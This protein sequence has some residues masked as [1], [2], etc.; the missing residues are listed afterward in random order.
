MSSTLARVQHILTRLLRLKVLLSTVLI[1][2]L[3]LVTYLSTPYDSSFRAFYRF[4]RNTLQGYLANRHSWISSA[5][6]HPVDIE[7]NVGVIIKTGYGTR[8]RVPKLLAAI[9]EEKFVTDTIVVQDYPVGLEAQYTWPNGDVVPTIDAIGWLIQNDLLKE[10][11]HSARLSK[12]S[13]VV[14]A[15]QAQDWAH[16]EELSR[17]VGWELDA[18]KVICS[19]DF[20]FHAVVVDDVVAFSSQQHF[21][22]VVRADAPRLVHTRHAVYLAN[23]AT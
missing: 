17:A 20:S 18:M 7:R 12:Y 13:S 19:F 6:L 1:L 2:I 23:N 14:E 10:Q 8:Q 4:H 3:L 11:E 15:I 21:V 5:G 22:D 9:A 16:A